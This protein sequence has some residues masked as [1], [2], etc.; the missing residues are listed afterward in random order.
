[1][2]FSGAHVE[3]AL[4]EI[5]H[6]FPSSSEVLRF[7]TAGSVDDG[8]STLIGRL[9]Y[10]SRSVYEDQLASVRNSR[11]NR[12]TGP[13]DFSLLT[14]GL[15]AER[16]Q[17]ITIDVAYRYFSTP[18]RKFIIAD[19]P[20]HEQYT[21]NMATGAS[22]ADAAIVL[23]DATKGV[24][25]QSRRHAY[26][27]S[28]LGIRHVIAAVNKM[29]IVAYSRDVFDRIA[30]D[31]AALAEKL[32]LRDTYVIPISALE[33]DNVVRESERMPWF[34]GPALLQYLEE[35]RIHDMEANAPGRFPVQYV[36][37]PGQS[38]RGFAGQVASGVFRPGQAVVAL[39]SRVKTRIKAVVSFD[40]DLKEARPGKSVTIALED[41]V[42]ISRGDLLAPEGEEP[43][44]SRRFRAKV[45]WMH[46]SELVCGK[47][48]MLKHTT[49]TVRAKILKVH[50]RVD[51]DSLDKLES[52]GL[53]MNDIGSVDVETTLPLYFDSYRDIRST[54]SLILIDQLSNATVAAGMIEEAIGAQRNASAAAAEPVSAEER[55]QRLGHKPTV[56][57]IEDNQ[58]VASMVERRLFDDGWLVNRVDA[59]G[60]QD[61]VFGAVVRALG[62][63]G[64]VIVVSTTDAEQKLRLKQD[65]AAWN[66]FEESSPNASA[67]ERANELVERLM[68]WREHAGREEATS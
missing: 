42:D 35:L 51:V 40:G 32:E 67:I 7:T 16:E 54:G 55:A 2:A 37:R 11:I 44:V 48:Y 20:G 13:L 52:N 68:K 9:L 34:D 23:I 39:P 15:R 18:R 31:F 49:R 17:G 41:E 50:Y 56:V 21:R 58:M 24:L 12:S 66:S 29:D 5:G 4:D 14:D 43:S 22:T 10:D 6:L 47:I 27:A 45:V 3:S 19:T 30:T 59:A 46:P 60:L 63:L 26:I 57:W 61:H 33:G 1:M 25:S 53:R 62:Q 38:F 65:F 28:L 8:K 36:I 64:A